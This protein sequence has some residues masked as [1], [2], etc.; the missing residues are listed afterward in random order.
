MQFAR[1]VAKQCKDS[2]GSRNVVIMIC[3]DQEV[4][5][6]R[7]VV[8]QISCDVCQANGATALEFSI[9]RAAFEID[10]CAEHRAAFTTAV[11]PYVSRARS[12]RS[13]TASSAAAAATRRDPSQTEAIRRWAKENGFAISTRGRIPATIEAAYSARSR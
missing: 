10:L 7:Q 4:R 6:A 1:I 3:V 2:H 9:D 5:M 8:V 12:S 11:S 13:R